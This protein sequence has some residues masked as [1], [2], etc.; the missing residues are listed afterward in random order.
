MTGIKVE[1][2]SLEDEQNCM[3]VIA[4]SILLHTR[5]LQTA[6]NALADGGCILAREK[7]DTE[8]VVSN[9][10]RLETV[11]EKT[12]KDEKLLLLRKGVMVESPVVIHVTGHNYDWLPEVQTAIS[13][14]SKHHIILVTQGEPHSGILGLV[15]CIRREPG[16]DYVRIMFMGWSSLGVI[17]GG[18]VSWE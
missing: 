12:L 17:R 7:V 3:L 9:G 11:F 16:S 4:S 14:S 2:L 1:E 8:N 5:L 13:S 6:M 10:F 15:N 18:I